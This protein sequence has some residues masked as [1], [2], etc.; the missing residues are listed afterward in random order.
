MTSQIVAVGL[1]DLQDFRADIPDG[2]SGY[3][4]DVNTKLPIRSVPS[5]V[6]SGTAVN[7]KALVLESLSLKSDTLPP[8]LKPCSMMLA[9]WRLNSQVCVEN[10]GTAR[11]GAGKVIPHTAAEGLGIHE[12]IRIKCRICRMREHRYQMSRIDALIGGKNHSC[13]QDYHSK[14]PILALRPFSGF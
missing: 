10:T 13:R 14:P 2:I 7:G 1:P 8:V 6:T 3:F 9:S 5:I 12:V 11:L 4:I